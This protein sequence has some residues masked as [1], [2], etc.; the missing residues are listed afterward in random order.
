MSVAAVAFASSALGP[1][2]SFQ[3]PK[4][5][6]A[7]KVGRWSKVFVGDAVDEASLEETVLSCVMVSDALLLFKVSSD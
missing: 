6:Y 1:V 7:P 5:E 3:H 2:A 4:R